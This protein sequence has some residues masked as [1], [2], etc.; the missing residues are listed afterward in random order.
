MPLPFPPRGLYAITP[1][2]LGD[3]ALLLAVELALE[4]GATAV[5]YRDKQRTAEQKTTMARQLQSLC[6]SK[7]VPLIIN[8]D[9]QLAKAVGAD[10]VHLGRDDGSIEQA[11]SILGNQAIIGVSCYGD[12]LRAIEAEQSGASYVA[13]GRFF[14]SHTKPDAKPVDPGILKQAK[15]SI[16]VPV[17]AIGG[18]SADNGAALI[19]AGADLLACVDSVF[20]CSDI[21]HCARTL[22]TL[23]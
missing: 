18:I 17:V 13:F 16:H 20:G 4:G 12:L 3:T 11:R 19:E 1:D 9:P 21:E 2:H 5:Q 7:N 23:F 15:T 14:P 10:G 22:Q 6:H 8:D